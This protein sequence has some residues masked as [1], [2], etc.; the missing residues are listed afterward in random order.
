[1]VIEWSDNLTDD[2]VEFVRK[3]CDDI[4]TKLA[5]DLENDQDNEQLQIEVCGWEQF[6]EN[7][8]CPGYEFS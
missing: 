3:M 8:G 1:M 2:Q 5:K 6:C 4:H 7:I